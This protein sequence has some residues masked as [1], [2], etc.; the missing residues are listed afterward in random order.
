MHHEVIKSFKN[1]NELGFQEMDTWWVSVL[2]KNQNIKLCNES[3]Y[4]IEIFLNETF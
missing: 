1:C 2:S 3:A 4:N